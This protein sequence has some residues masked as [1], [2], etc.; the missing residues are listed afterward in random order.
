MH[1]TAQ[2]ERM[3]P[4]Y[5]AAWPLIG[6][7]LLS[8]S[9]CQSAGALESPK[10]AA[11]SQTVA[12]TVPVVDL[13]VRKAPPKK[14]VLFATQEAQQKDSAR[15]ET[16]EADLRSLTDAANKDRQRLQELIL[17]LERAEEQRYSN[18]LVYT[19][20]A[21]LAVCLALLVF[22]PWRQQRNSHSSVPWWRGKT[23]EEPR[24]DD[25]VS[26]D[27]VQTDPRAFGPPSVAQVPKPKFT[28]LQKTVAAVPKQPSADLPLEPA[29]VMGHTVQ[30][31]SATTRQLNAQPTVATAPP[32]E[33]LPAPAGVSVAPFAA[34]FT[35]YGAGR[36]PAIDSQQLL[37]S[38]QQA[39]FFMALGR[40]DE[41]VGVLE[42][43]IKLATKP[44]PWMYL[45]L[46]A[47]YH[48]LSRKEDYEACRGAFTQLFM[49][50]VPT[51]A[52]YLQPSLGLETYADLCE[53]IST[54]W[55][56][57]KGAIDFMERRML[58]ANGTVV[59]P[60]IDL[61]AFCE[62]LMLHSIAVGNISGGASVGAAVAAT[63]SAAKPLK[64]APKLDLDIEVAKPSAYTVDFDLND[65]TDDSPA[66]SAKA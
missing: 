28:T 34:K 41:A 33:P 58:R 15:I 6:M 42:R 37:D 22:G 17:R 55:T 59:V 36:S 31:Q 30:Q 24:Q 51:Y 27:P 20:G 10:F 49:G 4:S 46:L 18:P 54:L 3:N 14:R 63:L 9:L 2:R 5:K 19:L 21:A 50:R 61:E 65:L 53:T 26:L 7:L 23:I 35:P 11:P 43:A 56:S 40:H 13:P 48:N 12:S 52:H 45:D 47:L 16:L 62:L 25:S 8:A 64:T 39:E 60:E 38:R 1:F 57:P 29:S 32:P 66:P 44:N